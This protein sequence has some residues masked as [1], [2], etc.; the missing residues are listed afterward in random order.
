MST[1]KGAEYARDRKTAL[2]V[3]H[4]GT[5]EIISFSPSALDVEEH[6]VHTGSNCAA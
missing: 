5:K 6:S 4:G 2:K 3:I 1:M